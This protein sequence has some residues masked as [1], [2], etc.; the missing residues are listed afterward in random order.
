[1]VHRHTC[2]QNT[3]IYIKILK[4]KKGRK[5]REIID[6]QLKVNMFDH[7]EAMFDQPALKG[8]PPDGRK[9]P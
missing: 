5:R 7:P 3:P 2:M 6:S 8:G 4:R 9:S 1:M